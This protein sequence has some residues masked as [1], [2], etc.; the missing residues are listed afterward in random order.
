M[1]RLG[2]SIVTFGPPLGL[3]GGLET[4]RHYFYRG[5]SLQLPP[6]HSLDLKM[7]MDRR[8]SVVREKGSVSFSLL[9]SILSSDLILGPRVLQTHGFFIYLFILTRVR[10]TLRL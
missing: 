4:G 2:L 3:D 6:T 5:V 9:L 8:C 7:G 10:L 1:G